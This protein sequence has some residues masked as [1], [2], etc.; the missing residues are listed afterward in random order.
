MRVSRFHNAPAGAK[1]AL[2]QG[3]FFRLLPGQALG[4]CLIPTAYAV[5][6][7][8]PPLPRLRIQDIPSTKRLRE[9]ALSGPD[10]ESLRRHI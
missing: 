3:S 4:D 6:Y 9:K 7:R 1:E 2:I 8:L 10:P 5:G